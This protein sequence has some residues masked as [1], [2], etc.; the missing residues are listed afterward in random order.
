MGQV[1]IEVEEIKNE[2]KE[3]KKQMK[4]RHNIL[5]FFDAVLLIILFLLFGAI[6]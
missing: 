1:L 3:I 6:S 5:L 2:L 4:L